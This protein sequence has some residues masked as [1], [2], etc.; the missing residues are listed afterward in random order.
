VLTG[1]LRG[2]GLNVSRLGAL[3]LEA[4]PRFWE[5]YSEDRKRS[6]TPAP[7]RPRPALWDDTGLHAAWL[8]HSTVLLKIEGVTILTDPVF[9]SRVGLNFGPM[10]LGLKR[11]VAPALPRTE[12]PQPDI[13]LLSHAH[14]D[15]FDLPSLRAL[16]SSKTAVVTAAKTS[17]LLRV[18]WYARVQELGWGEE[19]RLEDVTVRAFQVNHWGARLQSDTYRGFNGYVIQTP[20]YRVVFGGDT[21]MTDTFRG[22]RSARRFDLAIMPI[23]AYNPWIRAHCTP[24]QALRMADD[25]GAECVLPVHHR[26]FQLGKE[27]YHEPIGRLLAAAGKDP[28]RVALTDIGQEFHFQR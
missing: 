18:G 21:A 15:H 3:A 6:I 4:A 22:L 28:E 24:E 16:Q 14:M 5:R 2:S 27:P 25:A 17:D 9:S 20:N 11:I 1:T 23:G 13:V 7:H 8:G 10:T 26:T 19:V 12:T